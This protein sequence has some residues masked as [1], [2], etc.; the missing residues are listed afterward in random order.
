MTGVEVH[1]VTFDGAS[2]NINMCKC[3]GANFELGSN[4]KPYF[5]NS[6][7]KKKFSVFV[8]HVTC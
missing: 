3:L 1:S 6:T 4:F 5:I 7:T 2:V 8:I